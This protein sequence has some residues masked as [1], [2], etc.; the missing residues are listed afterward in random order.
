MTLE[1]DCYR[2]SSFEINF[3]AWSVA[4]SASGSGSA[5][6]WVT[7]A[8]Q[9]FQ[10]LPLAGPSLL[11]GKL[12]KRW[13]ITSKKHI[14]CAKLTCLDAVIGGHSKFLLVTWD[15]CRKRWQLLSCLLCKA[16]RN[17]SVRL[18]TGVAVPFKI[19]FDTFCQASY[20][21]G[22]QASILNLPLAL[23]VLQKRLQN[24][25]KQHAVMPW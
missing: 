25:Q 23:S 7:S 4:L 19:P 11:L 22:K 12:W 10:S 20:K 8:A 1:D 14:S 6:F 15:C 13:Q 5:C 17:E 21:R 16:L 24:V 9:A 18:G 2:Q 3:N